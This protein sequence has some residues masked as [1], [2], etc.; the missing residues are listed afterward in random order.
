MDELDFPLDSAGYRPDVHQPVDRW[1]QA[2]NASNARTTSA[3]LKLVDVENTGVVLDPFAGGGSTAIATRL[4][5]H[6]FYGIE[7]D[8]LLA[9]ITVAKAEGR[10]EYV[11][12]LPDTAGA[13]EQ[14]WLTEALTDIHTR[15]E[16]DRALVV[17]ALAVVVALRATMGAPLDAAALGADLAAMPT[18]AGPGRMV[19]GDATDPDTW[20]LLRLPRTGVLVYTSPPF[21]P[22]SPTLEAPPVLRD[23]A[24]RLL[25]GHGRLH[26]GATGNAAPEYVDIT[27]AMLH[28]LTE[29]VDRGALVLEHEPDDNKS[30][31]TDTLL[32]RIQDELGHVLHSPLV[33]RYDAFSARGPFT[34]ITHRIRRH[35]ARAARQNESRRT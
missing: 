7:H 9:A 11:R 12:S 34:L 14:E 16:E 26:T 29:H 22:S 5:G 28:R 17:S 35:R 19:C 21:G 23:Q 27:M 6:T 30:D 15:L 8:P 20:D 18:E 10:P 33:N 24:R 31:S 4:R 25:A 32:A 3:V 1:F 2:L 13:A